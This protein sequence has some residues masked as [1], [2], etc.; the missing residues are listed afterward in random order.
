VGTI[1]DKGD[2]WVEMSSSR[3]GIPF[4]YYARWVGGLPERGGGYDET[5]ISSLEELQLDDNIQLTWTFD[6][7]PRIVSFRAVGEEDDVFVPFYEKGD[8]FRPHPRPVMPSGPANPF[9]QV[10]PQTPNTVNPFDRGAASPFDNV[11]PN[12]SPIPSVSPFD[13]TPA[14]SLDPV[15]GAS[16]PFNQAS[17]PPD[18]T[19]SPFDPNIPANPFD[20]QPSPVRPIH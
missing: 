14:S 10:T 7:R 11:S 5:A 1:L 4:R 2:N 8:L 9:D 13:M 3:F 18:S 17:P 12:A 15:P 6:V 20:A 16:N 19:P